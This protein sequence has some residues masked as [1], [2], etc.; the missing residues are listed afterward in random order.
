M[1]PPCNHCIKNH[2]TLKFTQLNEELQ[3]TL[4]GSMWSNPNVRQQSNNN[5]HNRQFQSNHYNNNKHN[6]HRGG[7]DN[8]HH[9]RRG[10]F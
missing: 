5:S 6:S 8:R 4:D 1:L 2:P 7:H 3:H 10:R 9:N